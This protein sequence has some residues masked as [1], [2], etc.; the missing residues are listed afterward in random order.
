MQQVN[1]PSVRWEWISEAW[2]LFTRQWTVWVLMILVMYLIIFAIYLPFLGAIGMLMPTSQIGAPVEF[3]T[4]IFALYPVFYLVILCAASWLMAGLYNSAFKQI[5][6]EQIAIGDLFSGGPFFTRMLGALILIA[7]AAGIGSVLCVIP[8]LI[9]YGLAFLTY[10]MI[11]EGGKGT[12]DAIKASVEVTKRDWIMFTIF[13]VALYLIAMAGMIACG[14]GL[15][16][17]MPLLFL[18]QALAYRDCVGMS[19]AQSQGQFMPPP[20]AP[21]YRSYT[22]SQTPAQPQAQ[23]W[24]APTF[25]APPEPEPSTKTCPHCGASLARVVNFCNQCGR[26]LR[27]A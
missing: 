27:G 24:V 23:P 25:V 13:A 15:L 20:A 7:I 10:P 1:A 9:V 4:G 8:G 6:G 21:D 3:P 14:V 11:V 18:G 16:A 26:P 5:R 19:G 2:N 12:I 22:P 17:T